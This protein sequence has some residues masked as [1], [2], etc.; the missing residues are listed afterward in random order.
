MGQ[1]NFG[2]DKQAKTKRHVIK[3]GNLGLILKIEIIR[4]ETNK[5]D[6]SIQNLRINV[7]DNKILKKYPKTHLMNLTLTIKK[8]RWNVKNETKAK[9][10]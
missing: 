9:V 1:M 6:I 7:E 10:Q 2:K 3:E 8:E 4:T 5:K